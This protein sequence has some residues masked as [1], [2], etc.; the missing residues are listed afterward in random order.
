MTKGF[1]E[2]LQ[3]SISIGNGDTGPDRR[4]IGWSLHVT[5]RLRRQGPQ[6]AAAIAKDTKLSAPK[7][8]LDR[9]DF[10]GF[11]WPSQGTRLPWYVLA[12]VGMGRHSSKSSQIT[13]R[14][15]SSVMNGNAL[16][17]P[18]PPVLN[19][20]SSCAYSTSVGLQHLCCQLWCIGNIRMPW[21]SQVNSAQLA[22][23]RYHTT[24]PKRKWNT[25]Y[26]ALLTGEDSCQ[27]TLANFNVV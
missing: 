2:E 3:V 27:C 14:D 12:M 9:D 25:P 15:A 26:F 16:L 19:M 18:C 11:W 1:L 24:K 13:T 5:F 22:S 20:S 4:R 23:R 10:L 6:Y 17:T 21:H 8:F 7:L